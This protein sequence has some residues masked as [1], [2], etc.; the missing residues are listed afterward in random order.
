M[1]ALKEKIQDEK[2]EDFQADLL[3]L[4]Y[5]GEAINLVTRV[6]RG[7]HQA[8]EPDNI[9]RAQILLSQASFFLHRVQLWNVSTK[10]L[11]TNYSEKSEIGV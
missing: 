10:L 4:I 5:A 7:L 11:V 6:T 9:T 3:K 2:G 1:R 8:G